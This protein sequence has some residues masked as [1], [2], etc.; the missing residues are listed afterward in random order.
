M[1]FYWD[2]NYF[3]SLYMLKGYHMNIKGYYFTADCKK[4]E[5][6]PGEAAF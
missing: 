5:W 6:A 1:Y 2:I 3:L 4:V